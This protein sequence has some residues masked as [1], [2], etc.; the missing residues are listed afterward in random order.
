MLGA[1]TIAMRRAELVAVLGRCLGGTALRPKNPSLGQGALRSAR[2]SAR[3]LVVALAQP[4][5]REGQR[6]L[7]RLRTRRERSAAVKASRH[8]SSAAAG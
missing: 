4:A 8:E 3:R 7:D 1:E 2:A 5:K 6:R